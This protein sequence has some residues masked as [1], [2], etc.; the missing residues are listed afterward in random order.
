VIT[1][2]GISDEELTSQALAADPDEPLPKG[3]VPF[4]GEPTP[5][6][7]LLPEWYMPRPALGRSTPARR[8]IAVAVIAAALFINGLGF[9]ITYGHLSA[10]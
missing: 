3:A 8:A 7:D 10:G 6:I 2:Q 1:D 5:G 4:Q 9:C